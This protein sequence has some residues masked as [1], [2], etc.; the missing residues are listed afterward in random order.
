MQENKIINQ[1]NNLPTTVEDLSKFVLIGREKLNAVRA[2]IRAIDKVEF[3]TEVREQKL[4]EAQDI[5]EAVLDAEV[6]LGELIAQLPKATSTN[7]PSGTKKT[8][9]DTA[10][11][12]GSDF[13]NDSDIEFKKAE[14]KP[15]DDSDFWDTVFESSQEPATEEP[16]SPTKKEL[17]E[18]AGITQKQAERFQTLAEHPELVEKAKAEARENGD[19]VTRSSALNLI[20]TEKKKQ[21]REKKARRKDFSLEQTIP[22][23]YCTLFCEDIRNGLASIE[24]NSIDYI[25]TDPPYPKEYISLYS[26]L[27]KT[28]KRVLKPNG[29]L[30]VMTGQSYLPE[31]ISRMSEHMNYHWCLAYVTPGGQSPQLF[32]K[33]VNTFWKPVLWFVKDEYTGDW[34]GDVLKSPVNDND[35]R[36]HEWGQSLGGFKNIVERFTNPGDTI[37]DPFLGG[38]TTGVAAVTMKRKFIGIDI[39]QEN[40]S[41][42]DTRIKEAYAECLK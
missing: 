34:V 35:K 14:T 13:K 21:N 39:E 29:S 8:Q 6:R 33:K 3:A 15:S 31:V 19:I 41:V 12:L 20:K 28:A 22:D 7:N 25:I 24:D 17:I 9:I 11:D 16:K 18:A 30:I 26:D 1:Q 37:L 4:S 5:A 32:N 10:V 23:G 2:E 27:A 42:S 38:G 36:F 40:V